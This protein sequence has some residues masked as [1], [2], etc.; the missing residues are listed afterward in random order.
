M[1][2]KVESLQIATVR[3]FISQEEVEGQPLQVV[4]AATDMNIVLHKPE[5]TGVKL[6]AMSKKIAQL[7]AEVMDFDNTPEEIMQRD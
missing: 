6:E 1:I 7:F 4:A 2:Q 3:I 5:Q